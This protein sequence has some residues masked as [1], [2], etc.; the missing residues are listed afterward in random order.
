[1][2]RTR[3]L[4]E[5]AERVNASSRQLRRAFSEV[6]GTTFSS[7]LREVRMSRAADLLRETDAPIQEIAAA[8]GYGEPSQ[9][10]KAFRRSFGITPTVYRLRGPE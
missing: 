9:F 10:T 7:Y 4:D 2:A 8:V 3:T 6:G 5:L 1:M